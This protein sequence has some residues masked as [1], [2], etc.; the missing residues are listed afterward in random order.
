MAENTDESSLAHL[1]LTSCCTDGTRDPCSKELSYPCGKIRKTFR[2]EVA[3][4]TLKFGCNSSMRN[5]LLG[6]T[7]QAEGAACE[8]CGGE[9]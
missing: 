9:R 2:K 4:K 1:P 7:F 6:V 5:W 8:K 3:F